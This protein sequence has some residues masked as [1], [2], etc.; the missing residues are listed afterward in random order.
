MIEELKW[1]SLN[2]MFLTR[3]DQKVIENLARAAEEEWISMAA[4]IG[5]DVNEAPC[6]MIP[7][8]QKVFIQHHGIEEWQ[9]KKKCRERDECLEKLKK[10]GVVE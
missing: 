4:T 7:Y 10:L 1:K 9:G 2:G 3:L 6:Y 8:S 5:V